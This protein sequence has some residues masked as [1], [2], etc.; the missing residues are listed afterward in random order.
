M[1]TQSRRCHC[2]GFCP[3][4]GEVVARRSGA[5]QPAAARRL[6]PW[7]SAEGRDAHGIGE[8][9]AHE[10]LGRFAPPCAKCAN[11]S[12]RALWQRLAAG[13]EPQPAAITLRATSRRE[14]QL[15]NADVVHASILSSVPAKC[16]HPKMQGYGLHPYCVLMFRTNWP[17]K[18]PHLR[19][20]RRGILLPNQEP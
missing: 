11:L 2:S 20:S 12:R 13:R 7:P 19:L 1:R 5:A 10:R 9:A 16:L 6:A 14:P 18:A 3:H 4:P 17:W 15:S 8:A